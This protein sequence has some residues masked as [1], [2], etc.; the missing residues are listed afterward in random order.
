MS[1]HKAVSNPPPMANPFTAAISG[2]S[3]SKR[4][5]RPA[6]PVGGGVPLPPWAVYLRSLPA[7]NALSPAPVS[8]ATHKSSSAAKSSHTRDISLCMGACTALYTSGRFMVTIRIGPR[9]SLLTNSYAMSVSLSGG[10]RCTFV[11]IRLIGIG[12]AA[13]LHGLAGGASRATVDLAGGATG[14]RAVLP[15]EPF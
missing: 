11:G 9:R 4:V 14:Q 1:Q 15:P 8:T 13:I 12:V 5:D 10:R 6:N 7:E 2:F 3:R